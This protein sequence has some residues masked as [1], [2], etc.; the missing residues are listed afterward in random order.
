MRLAAELFVGLIGLLTAS[1]QSPLSK[2][3]RTPLSGADYVRLTDWAKVF[4]FQIHWMRQNEEV[5]LTNSLSRL[6]FA[7]DSQRAEINDVTVFLSAPVLARK[8]TVYVLAIR[9][10]AGIIEKTVNVDNGHADHRAPI[11]AIVSGIDDSPDDFHSIDF[12]AVHSGG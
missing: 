4:N 11:H 2:L 8:G 5:Q 3:E 6:V 7:L 10:I 12:I 9:D 1:A